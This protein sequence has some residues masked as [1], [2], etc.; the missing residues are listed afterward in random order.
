MSLSNMRL[1][2]I[3]YLSCSRGRTGTSLAG[4]NRSI[5]WDRWTGTTNSIS[6]GSTSVGVVLNGEA[7]CGGMDGNDITGDDEEACD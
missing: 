6:A 7:S 5:Q 1:G 2:M 4:S 3:L